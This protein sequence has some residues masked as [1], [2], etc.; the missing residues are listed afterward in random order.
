MY[1][2]LDTRGVTRLLLSVSVYHVRL[3]VFRPPDSRTET[4]GL[5]QPD[6]HLSLVRDGMCFPL[7]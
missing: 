1:E 4:A 6:I 3:F 2:M 5:P 7:G